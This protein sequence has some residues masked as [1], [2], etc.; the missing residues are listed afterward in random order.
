MKDIPMKDIP[1]KDEPMNKID[2]NI[3]SSFIY[4]S[5]HLPL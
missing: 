5:I 3:S 4:S 2:R 1:I